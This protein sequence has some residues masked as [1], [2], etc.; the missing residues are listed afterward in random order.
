MILISKCPEKSVKARARGEKRG[1][2]SLKNSQNG[3]CL[4]VNT[5]CP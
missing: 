3:G 4:N 5:G 2:A 1:L